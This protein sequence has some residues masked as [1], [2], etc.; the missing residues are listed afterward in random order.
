M[1]C[2]VAFS[3]LWPQRTDSSPT[4][5]FLRLLPARQYISAGAR[6]PRMAEILENHRTL[7]L[8][9][10]AMTSEPQ[11]AARLLA[12]INKNENIL[13]ILSRIDPIPLERAQTELAGLNEA[14]EQIKSLRRSV[15]ALEPETQQILLGNEQFL[16]HAKS[17]AEMRLLAAEVHH[18]G[19]QGIAI[20]R[21][22]LKAALAKAKRRWHAFY[23]TPPSATREPGAFLREE[24][25]LAQEVERLQGKLSDLLDLEITLSGSIVREFSYKHPYAAIADAESL[26][27]VLRDEMNRLRGNLDEAHR[28]QHGVRQA[29]AA[30]D[31]MAEALE[32]AKRRLDVMKQV[33]DAWTEFLHA[34]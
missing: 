6:G 10:A 17:L 9:H 7:Y 28:Q 34:P 31:A 13:K 29:R 26:V 12:A 22:K 24:E 33:G 27:R 19:P 30:Y 2:A 14:V 3:L 25:N 18:E 21:E 15:G 32:E 11:A 8:Q 1:G 23:T 16:T 4:S 20:V 5:S